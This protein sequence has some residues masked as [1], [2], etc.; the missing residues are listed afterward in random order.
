MDVTRRLRPLRAS[1]GSTISYLAIGILAACPAVAEA[2]PDRE[3]SSPVTVIDRED[4]ERSDA[5]NVSDLIN[6]LPQSRDMQAVLEMHNTAR[7][8]V[9]SAPLRWNPTLARGAQDYAEV[10]ARTGSFEHSSYQAR[11]GGNYS[12]NLSLGPIPGMKVKDL[13]QIWFDEEKLF[14]GGAFPDIC[15]GDWS[16]CGHY[17]QMIWSTTTDLGCGYASE[18]YSALV[19][20]YQPQGNMFGQPVLGVPPVQIAQGPMKNIGNP[21]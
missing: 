19:C 16:L 4:F 1:L 15:D 9:R 21:P 17:S 5:A 13:V 8:E 10:Q 12:E 18:S 14:T 7:A 3:T 20:F 2:R 11:M 6:A